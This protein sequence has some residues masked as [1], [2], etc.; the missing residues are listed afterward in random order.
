MCRD[1]W[2]TN[3]II[4]IG[5][6]RNTDFIKVYIEATMHHGSLVLG[7]SHTRFTL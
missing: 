2:K 7:F 3:Q 1:F 4:T 6:L 5:I